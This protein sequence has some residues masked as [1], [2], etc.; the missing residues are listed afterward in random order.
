MEASD[1]CSRVCLL[2]PDLAPLVAGVSHGQTRDHTQTGA[3]VRGPGGG[4]PPPVL[5]TVNIPLPAHFTVTLCQKIF[6]LLL[7]LCLHDLS[8]ADQ[9]KRLWSGW[10]GVSY[11]VLSGGAEVSLGKADLAIAAG[12]DLGPLPVPRPVPGHPI[13]QEPAPVVLSRIILSRWS[14]VVSVVSVSAE[15]VLRLSECETQEQNEKR[16]LEKKDSELTHNLFGIT[17]LIWIMINDN[18]LIFCVKL[19]PRVTVG[20]C[21]H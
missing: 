9:D 12:V 2:M 17:K 6:G 7:L 8:R 13:P 5:Q 21:S 14:P 15:V 20:L 10:H 19:Y 3:G 11:L 4:A 18:E 1:W 16:G